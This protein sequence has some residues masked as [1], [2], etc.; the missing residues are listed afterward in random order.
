MGDVAVLVEELFGCLFRTKGQAFRKDGLIAVVTAR[1]ND[2]EDWRRL[3]GFIDQATANPDRQRRNIGTNCVLNIGD[4][5]AQGILRISCNG[6][7]SSGTE[8][9]AFLLNLVIFEND[10]Y[11]R[12]T[13]LIGIGRLRTPDNG[14]RLRLRT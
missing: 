14:D 2:Q 8:G 10:G 13:A 3:D 12:S 4:D 9:T 7:D 6:G 5:F 11:G 1:P